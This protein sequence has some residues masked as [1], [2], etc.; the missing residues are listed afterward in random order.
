MNKNSKKKRIKKRVDIWQKTGLLLEEIKCDELR[1]PN[2][3]KKNQALLN[4]ML[5]Y[6]FEHRTVRLSSGLIEQQKLFMKYYK[7]KNE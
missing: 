5:K 2:Y 3:Y 7:Q 4:E 1:A 6:A